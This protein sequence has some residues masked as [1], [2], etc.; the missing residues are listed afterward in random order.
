MDHVHAAS[1]SELRASAGSLPGW[2]PF[3]FASASD[4]AVSEPPDP[5]TSA[6]ETFQRYSA[7]RGFSLAVSAVAA[8]PAVAAGGPMADDLDREFDRCRV[9]E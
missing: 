8:A 6:A 7:T 9:T 2:S 1:T 3:G 5:A 4:R